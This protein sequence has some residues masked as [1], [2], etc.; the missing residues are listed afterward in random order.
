M[1]QNLTFS[2]KLYIGDSMNIQ[3]LDKL[4][5]RLL[6]APAFTKVFLVTI[7]TNRSELLDILESRYLAF[8]FYN[9]HPLHVVGIAK[10]NGEAARLVKKIV[11]DCLDARKDVDLKAFLLEGDS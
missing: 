7:A 2:E 1:I 5:E 8:P 4:K 3:K 9:T 11:Q 10:T 6:Q